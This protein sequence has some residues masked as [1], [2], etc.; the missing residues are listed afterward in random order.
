MEAIVPLLHRPDPQFPLPLGPSLV[1]PPQTET[2]LYQAG[3]GPTF[4]ITPKEAQAQV[5][6]LALQAHIHLPLQD[7]HL[8]RLLP[9]HHPHPAHLVHMDIQSLIRIHFHTHCLKLAELLMEVCLENNIM[10]HSA[11]FE[12]M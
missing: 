3:V 8:P 2:A 7:R 4:P 11:K 5:Q 1:F 9:L 12:F 6:A 10:V